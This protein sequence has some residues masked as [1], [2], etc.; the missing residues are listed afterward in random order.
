MHTPLLRIVALVVALACATEPVCAGGDPPN[1]LILLID[2]LGPDQLRCYDRA[3]GI[4]G[5]APG[6]NHYDPQEPY[7]YPSTPNITQIAREGVRFTRAFANP[8]S[9]PSRASFQTGRYPFR[10]KIGTIVFEDGETVDGTPQQLDLD[11]CELILPEMFGDPSPYQLAFFG[12]WHLSRDDVLS[13]NPGQFDGDAH[14]ALMGWPFYKGMSRNPQSRPNPQLDPPTPNGELP[15]YFNWYEV[16]SDGVTTTRVLRREYATTKQRK[17]VEEW[18]LAA[19]EDPSGK[20]W[21]A[22]WS[23]T[24]AHSIWDWPP[25]G[26]GTLHG[27]GS[28]PPYAA[29]WLRYMAVIEALDTEFGNLRAALSEGPGETI[30]DRTLVMVVGDN[31]SDRVPLQLAEAQGISIGDYDPLQFKGTVYYAGTGVPLIVSGPEPYV[32]RRGA[33]EDELV[34]MVDFLDTVREACGLPVSVLNGITHDSRS[35]LPYL[36]GAPITP[37]EDSLAM[38]FKPNGPFPPTAPGNVVRMGYARWVGTSLYRLI[39]TDLS[40]TGDEFYLLADAG[41]EV[42]PL[43]QSPLDV[44]QPPHQAPY[45]TVVAALQALLANPASCP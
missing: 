8:I 40:G 21:L 27:Y 6:L 33:T 24:A 22:V 44:S 45:Q 38:F 30:W 34:D 10:N 16:T 11:A 41:G 7:P 13:G 26:D 37:R 25:G 31:G 42:D 43:E 35:F 2:D 15:G 39:R 5:L 32:T 1:V 9:S 18:I 29:G 19:E 14:P 28:E 36:S 23:A 3:P 4:P 12:K 17:D 20:P